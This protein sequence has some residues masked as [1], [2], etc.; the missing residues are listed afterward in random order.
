MNRTFKAAVA[1]LVLA[2]GF[3]RS[4]TAGP[5]EDAAV[6]YRIGNYATAL[7]LV[8]PLAEQGNS[9]AQTLLGGMYANGYG[10]PQDYAAA[11]NWY[12]KAA[13][14]GFAGA[15]FALGVMYV[16]GRG[17]PQ[18]N[19]IAHMWF[20]LAASGG[21]KNAAWAR[22]EVAAKMTPAQ[23]TEAQKLARE[24][25]PTSTSAPRWRK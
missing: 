25:K 19:V 9:G 17:V 16:I 5:L 3:A 22:Q 15:Q 23:I 20:N 14:H 4:V 7:E 6:A 11:M 13:E 12:R 10:V 8:R 18:D 1:A 2:V 24:W 21:S